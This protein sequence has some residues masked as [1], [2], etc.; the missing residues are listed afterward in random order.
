VQIC[1]WHFAAREGFAADLRSQDAMLTDSEVDAAYRELLDV[2][3]AVQAEQ[4]KLLTATLRRAHVSRE[5]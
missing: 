5:S 4:R 2:V 1:D 3:E